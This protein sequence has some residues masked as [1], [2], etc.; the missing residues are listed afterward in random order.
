MDRLC[1]GNSQA[2]RLDIGRLAR[3]KVASHVVEK[4]LLHSG[5][6]ER[7]RL[8]EAMASNAEEGL[9][10]SCFTSESYRKRSFEAFSGFFH[11]FFMVLVKVSRCFQAFS[12]VLIAFL[13]FA[14][15]CQRLGAH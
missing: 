14:G 15:A 1:A 10:E 12:M 13:S 8:K 4:A 7:R 2:M 5:P 9:R 6:E 11:G 3:H